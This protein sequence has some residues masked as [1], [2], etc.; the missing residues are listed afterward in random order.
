MRVSSSAV[1]FSYA[2]NSSRLREAPFVSRFPGLGWHR[3]LA[4]AEIRLLSEKWDNLFP[5]QAERR[6]HLTLLTH[7]VAEE[8]MVTAQRPILLDLGDDFLRSANDQ[9]FEFFAGK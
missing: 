1:K 9:G 8:K 3:P 5:E 7:D 4:G 2:T 6:K